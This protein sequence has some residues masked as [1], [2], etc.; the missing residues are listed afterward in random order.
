[1]ADNLSHGVYG[2]PLAGSSSHD[3]AIDDFR[4]AAFTPAISPDGRWIAWGETSTDW[5]QNVYVSQI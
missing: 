1:M 2:A 3:R 4:Q 5:E